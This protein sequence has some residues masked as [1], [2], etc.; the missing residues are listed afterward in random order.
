MLT[1]RIGGHLGRLAGAQGMRLY[2]FVP[3]QQSF[4]AVPLAQVRAYALGDGLH[5]A[6]VLGCKLQKICR[7]AFKC[8][9]GNDNKILCVG[10]L[11]PV[12]NVSP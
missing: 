2:D 3:L 8:T 9:H 6:E 4:L 11:L 12:V 7:I 1:F 5:S 10:C